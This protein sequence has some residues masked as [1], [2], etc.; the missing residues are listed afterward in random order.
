MQ[1]KLI[2]A[3]IEFEQLCAHIVWFYN[4]YVHDWLPAV[5]CDYLFVEVL[6]TVY[7]WLNL[8]RTGSFSIINH[9]LKISAYF[10]ELPESLETNIQEAV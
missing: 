3:V 4:R 10:W 7:E 9:E 2:A 8:L 6:K 5:Y 1:R